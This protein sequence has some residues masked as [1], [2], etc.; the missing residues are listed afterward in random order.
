MNEQLLKWLRSNRNQSFDSPRRTIF[1]TNTQRFEIIK[2]NEAKGIVEIEF[3]KRYTRLRLEFWRFETTL[4][5]LERN[6]GKW[7]RLATK[8]YSDDPDTV[9]YQ[10]Q[11]KARQVHPNRHVDLKSASHVC[12]L[13]VLSGIAEYGRTLNPMTYREN[14]AI[15]L[16]KT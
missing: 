5:F 2:V 1:G 16:V 15:R 10:I 4:V 7:T 6:R 3:K 14:Q 8:F 12:D 13:L 9:E 11:R